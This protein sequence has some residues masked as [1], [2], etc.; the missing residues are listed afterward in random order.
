MKAEVLDTSSFKQV[1]ETP[2]R[3]PEKFVFRRTMK[4]P[5]SYQRTF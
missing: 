4:E 1:V 2:F 5:Q 3:L